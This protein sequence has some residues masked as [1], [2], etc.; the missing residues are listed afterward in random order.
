M[1]KFDKFNTR[2]PIKS[3]GSLDVNYRYRILNMNRTNGC[4]YGPTIKATLELY[5]VFLP[6]SYAERLTD[7]DIEEFNSETVDL[8]YRGTEDRVF[9]VEII[10]A[11]E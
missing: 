5:E 2:K 6:K 3:I 10:P 4:K 7:K 11:V 9:I 1:D 8:V